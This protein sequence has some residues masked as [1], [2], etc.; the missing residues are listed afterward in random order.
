M[1]FAA[2]VGMAVLS[3]EGPVPN[4]KSFKSI[5]RDTDRI[6]WP[7][8]HRGWWAAH[9][10]CMAKLVL[11]PKGA[12]AYGGNHQSPS[13]RPVERWK[14]RGSECRQ[15]K[16]RRFAVV[17]TGNDNRARHA[18]ATSASVE[19]PMAGGGQKTTAVNVSKA[20]NFPALNAGQL[21]PENTGERA[22]TRIRDGW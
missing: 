21:K 14:G 13:T 4:S 16:T 9:S 1:I 8:P 18:H 19:A 3:E 15:G 7:K 22:I 5:G 11:T 17:V 12:D 2:Q 20:Q 10:L 6:N